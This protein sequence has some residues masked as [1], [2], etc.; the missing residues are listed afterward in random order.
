MLA[1]VLGE[2]KISCCFGRTQLKNGYYCVRNSLLHAK[3]YLK[4]VSIFKNY[5]QKSQLKRQVQIV[6]YIIVIFTITIITVI[7]LQF[8]FLYLVLLIRF[9]LLIRFQHFCIM[10]QQ[11]RMGG[12]SQ[13]YDSRYLKKCNTRTAQ[14]GLNLDQLQ[15]VLF[16]IL[17]MSYLTT[18][19]GI[20][21]FGD[22]YEYEQRY[23]I[24]LGSMNFFYQQPK[25]RYIF[26]PLP[27]TLL[28]IH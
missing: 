8:L 13:K 18:F 17:F 28:F 19:F 7:N 12:I 21:F 11:N 3:L 24:C 1:Y 4:G 26:V 14:K 23:D 5:E 2:F 6:I 9:L 25:S 27:F 20:S 10:C 15:I 16:R 22:V